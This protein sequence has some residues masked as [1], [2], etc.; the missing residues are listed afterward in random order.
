M[1]IQ[2]VLADPHPVMLDGLQSVFRDE[3][4]FSVCSS[5]LDGEAA[6]RDVQRLRPHVLI[7]ELNLPKV[8][9]WRLIHAIRSN[10]IRTI[11]V[12]FTSEPWPQIEHARQLGLIGLIGKDKPRHVLLDCVRSVLHGHVW[13]DSHLPGHAADT[14]QVITSKLDLPQPLTAREWSV[15]KLVVEGLPN[16]R[17][18]QK[19]NITEGTAKLH[20]HHVYQKLQCPGRMA[21]M[22]YMKDKGLN[23]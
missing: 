7:H 9:G 20:L 15:A 22:I 13:L 11:P 4:G 3:T 19:L 18:A 21:L 10:G 16:K 1:S 12:V 8:N 14:L 5:V 2:L 6:W 23:G 17:I